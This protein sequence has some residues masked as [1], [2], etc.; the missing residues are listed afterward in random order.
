MGR[1]GIIKREAYDPDK[2][3]K[4]YMAILAASKNNTVQ[5]YEMLIDDLKVVPRTSDPEKFNN[6]SEFVTATSDHLTIYM[7]YGASK[8]ADTYFFYFRGVP[9]NKMHSQSLAGIE[10]IEKQQREKIEKEIYYEGLEKENEELKAEIQELEEDFAKQQEHWENIKTGKIHTI[11][12]MGSAILLSLASNPTVQR[13]FPGLKML[14]GLGQVPKQEGNNSSQEET[15]T[16][17]RKDEKSQEPDPQ[18]DLTEDDRMI[19]GLFRDLPKLLDRQQMEMM[20]HVLFALAENPAALK[21][22]HKHIQN[23]IKS[24]PN[25][26]NAAA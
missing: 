5:D 7:Y 2:L 24:K 12:E 15:A 4:I 11:G 1:I 20:I 8:H 9:I 6:F 22:T 10:E 26:D 3:D 13:A 18:S 23:F 14:G 19:V 25:S 16:F 17:R 21:S